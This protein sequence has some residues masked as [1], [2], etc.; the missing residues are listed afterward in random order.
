M[1]TKLLCCPAY[2]LKDHPA[3]AAVAMGECLLCSEPDLVRWA[4][5]RV[6]HLIDAADKDVLAGDVKHTRLLEI[7]MTVYPADVTWITAQKN[8]CGATG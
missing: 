5:T 4:V 2:E 1:F 3:A 7:S 8:L 6:H